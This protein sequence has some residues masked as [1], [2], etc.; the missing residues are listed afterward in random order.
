M[1]VVFPLVGVLLY[2]RF[3]G[4]GSTIAASAP[5]VL[6]RRR[7]TATLRSSVAT[8]TDDLA[9]LSELHGRGVLTDEEFRAGEGQ[10]PELAVGVGRPRQRRR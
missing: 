6:S 3:R 9:A 8:P 4:D 2:L 1:I 10:G 5:P 7:C